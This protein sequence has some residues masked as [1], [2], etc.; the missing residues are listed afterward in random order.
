MVKSEKVPFGYIYRATNIQNGKNYIGQTVTSRWGVNKNP[1][2][3][4]WREEVRESY[5]RQRRGENL[6][7]IEKAIIKHGSENFKLKEQ[8][9]ASN[10]KE[11]DKKETHYINDYDSMN[12][13]KG[14]NMKEGGLG[15]R[16]SELAKENLS[17]K[18]AEKWREDI[19]YQQ[20]QLNERQE[21]AKDPEWLKK[22]AE[23]NQEIARNPET[24]KKM[25]KAISEKWQEKEYQE[26]VSKGV[27]NKWQEP[28]F[29]ERQFNAKVYGRR[30][31]PDRAEFL[32]D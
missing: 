12:P 26:N 25:S 24:L 27:S 14:Y 13:D 30:E 8:D 7:Y 17:K 28:K 11:L 29:R 32:K 22:M 23:V 31:I 9:K 10:Q 21:R 18:G 3:E 16:L 20:K 4:R 15:G 5:A 6:R 19:V 1:V 2:E